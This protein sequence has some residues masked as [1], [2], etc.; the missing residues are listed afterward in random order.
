MRV[1]RVLALA[2]GVFCEKSKALSWLRK[3]K[4]HFE[5]RPIELL[6]MD[7]GSRVVEELLYQIDYGM[8]A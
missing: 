7:V 1:G 3:S 2:E 4:R 8:A 6:S 5:N